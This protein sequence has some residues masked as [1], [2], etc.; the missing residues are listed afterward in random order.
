MWGGGGSSMAPVIH[1]QDG[2]GAS[3]EGIPPK[4]F[5]RPFLVD[6]L[7]MSR[8]PPRK[9]FW[10]LFLA[11]G[12]PLILGRWVSGLGGGAPLSPTYGAGSFQIGVG[13]VRLNTQKTLRKKLGRLILRYPHKKGNPLSLWNFEIFPKKDFSEKKK[14]YSI[15]WNLISFKKKWKKY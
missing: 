8:G 14:K 13:G 7:R 6:A 5:C 15:N 4:M 1:G 11:L 9:I 2:E 12:V 3:D 10:D